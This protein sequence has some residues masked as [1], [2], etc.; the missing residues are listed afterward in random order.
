MLKKKTKILDP[1]PL[2]VK[3]RSLRKKT[4][5]RMAIYGSIA[6]LF[7]FTLLN[8]LFSRK[9][10]STSGFITMLILVGIILW[11][12]FSWLKNHRLTSAFPKYLH[13]ISVADTLHTRHLASAMG[14]PQDKLLSNTRRL[15]QLGLL[16][17]VS[18]EK[19]GKYALVDVKNHPMALWMQ[20]AK[21]EKVKYHA[22]LRPVKCPTCG[23]ESIVPRGK[24]TPCPYCGTGLRKR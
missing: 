17:A 12:F 8:E 16:P 5:I 23:A 7:V 3:L 13:E 10:L 2:A 6:F 1:M 19:D 14:I 20:D 11:K 9:Q 21:E 4:K 18:A 24:A 15:T 22:S